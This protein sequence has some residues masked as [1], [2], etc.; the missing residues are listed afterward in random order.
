MIALTL[1][2]VDEQHLLSRRARD[3]PIIAIYGGRQ[4]NDDG[5]R[6]KKKVRMEK[7]GPRCDL[8]YDVILLA[9]CSSADQSS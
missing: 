3:V 6:K 1:M 9:H 7:G 2:N 5:K 8:E 4:A